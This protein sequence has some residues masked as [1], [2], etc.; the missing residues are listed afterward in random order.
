MD[1]F[2][3]KMVWIGLRL[4]HICVCVGSGFVWIGSGLDRFEIRMDWNG[5]QLIH[6]GLCWVGFGLGWVG[7]GSAW[8]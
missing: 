5:L 4:I 6:V 3:I 2:E 7:L 1:R 8:Q